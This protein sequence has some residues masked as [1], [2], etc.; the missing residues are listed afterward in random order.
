[1][2]SHV[3]LDHAAATPLDP[4]VYSAMQPLVTEQ[5]YNPS[6]TYLAAQNVRRLLESAR[7]DVA[8]CLGSRPTEIVLTA[9][10][11]E[12]NNLAIRGV[13]A[14]NQEKK[15]LVSS[16]EHDSVLAPA[17]R[18]ERLLIPVTS[19]GIIDMAAFA[20]LL[21]DDVAMVSV[22]YVNNELGTVQ[23]IAAIAALLAERYPSVATRPLLHTDACQAPLYLDVHVHRLG[24]DLM[25][26]N[27]SKLYGPRQTGALFVRAGLALEP[28]IYGGGQEQTL[29]SGTENTAGAVGLATA[30]SAAQMHRKPE[31]AR[32]RAI[33]Q[34]F[35]QELLATV[36]NIQI[37]GSRKQRTPNNIHVTLPGTDNERI[38]MQLDQ[39]G[40]AVAVGSACSAS[41]ELPSHVL[42]AMGLSEA[43][44][45]SSL[46]ITMGRST[47][48]EAMQRFV[49]ALQDILGH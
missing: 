12:A 34:Q 49:K 23:P 6:A 39:A 18:Y 44:A 20:K 46:R 4:A 27:G 11:S 15:I 35:I 32:L 37:N 45:Q 17:E 2:V 41:S 24:V 7:A 9:G 16:I 14:R 28:L 10:G 42:M 5:F 22:M 21:D 31:G 19:E 25:T 30:L 3:Y 38:M 40:F 36:P 33:Q 26:I 29:R 47:T 43:D 8:Q 13:M 48:P 1:M